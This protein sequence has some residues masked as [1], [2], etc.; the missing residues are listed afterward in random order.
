MKFI[1]DYVK[2]LI[3]GQNNYNLKTGDLIYIY[4][5]QKS[6]QRTRAIIKVY[7]KKGFVVSDNGIGNINYSEKPTIKLIS[8]NFIKKYCKENKKIKRKVWVGRIPVNE[9]SWVVKNRLD[10]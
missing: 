8:R 1:F 3:Y 4:P 10:E 6:S 9:F 7:G 5:N 2:K